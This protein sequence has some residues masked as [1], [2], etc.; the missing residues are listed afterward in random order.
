MAGRD[1]DRVARLAG[2]DAGLLA[3][4]TFVVEPGTVRLFGES[5]SRKDWSP[6]Q[7]RLC[8]ECV[9]ED[10]C[11]VGDPAPRAFRR[12][13]WDLPSIRLCPRHGTE[14]VHPASGCGTNSASPILG[15]Q[16]TL[17][18]E[19]YVLGRLG[20]AERR[21]VDLLDQLT[22]GKVL[23]LLERCGAMRLHG[24][25]ARS[26]A[27][28]VDMRPLLSA[29]MSAYEG[30]ASPFRA[31]LDDLV[32]TARPG[33]LELSPRMAYGRLH[34]WLAHDERDAAYDPVRE[35]LRE[36]AL[37]TMPLRPG[38]MLYG[39]RIDESA[40]RTVAQVCDATGLEPATAAR[41]L[42]LVGAMP[43]PGP[44]PIPLYH[45]A[46][47]SRVADLVAASCW[48]REARSRL[49]LTN[50]GMVSLVAS[51]CL[52]PMIPR[53]GLGIREDRFARRDIDGLIS[54]V[55]GNRPIFEEVPAGCAMLSDAARRGM[56]S[57]GA[58][59][60]AVMDGLL[61]PR[62]VLEGRPGVSGLIFEICEVFSM[63]RKETSDVPWSE[64]VSHLGS[65]RVARALADS[66]RLKLR[67]G[68]CGFRNRYRREVS[69]T[70]WSTFRK[71]YVSAVELARQNGRSGVAIAR[72][73]ADADMQPA[74]PPETCGGRAFYPRRAASRLAKA[75]TGRA[76]CEK[77]LVRRG[78]VRVRSSR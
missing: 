50:E 43:A 26:D 54:D 47:C 53:T 23:P 38:Q 70:D 36:H 65:R 71:T 60:R 25:W 64:V 4:S 32:A 6:A 61:M 7:R 55:V 51:G 2:V 30:G 41:M 42:D 3:A 8:R 22:L 59:V 29:G 72:L 28:D 16:T 75:A 14:L 15:V 62:G 17:S 18:G 58:V 5:L 49:G 13:W 52:V 10:E 35:A 46:D 40:L 74:I 56:S 77:D 31:F 21:S 33:R 12:T 78:A 1:T 76:P 57:I 19:T 34:A 66:G 69:A 63:H 9:A 11:R 48:S 24:R 27:R 45:A 20:F 44:S 37:A 73:L 39:R 67:R 68:S